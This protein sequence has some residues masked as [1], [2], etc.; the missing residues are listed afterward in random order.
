MCSPRYLLSLAA[1][2]LFATFLFASQPSHFSSRGT[3]CRARTTRSTLEQTQ[4]T[5]QEPVQSNPPDARFPI[6]EQ[7]S[8]QLSLP[9]TF[10]ANL[11]QADPQIAFLA[12]GQRISTFLTRTG[13]DLESARRSI[14]GGQPARVHLEFTRSANAS[15]DATT[16]KAHPI[17]WSGLEKLPAEGNYFIGNN[18]QRWRTHVPHFARAQARA[19][20][21]GVELIAYGR[22]AQL[23]FDLRVAP[24]ANVKNLRIKITGAKD[25]HLNAE[26]DLSLQLGAT[27]IR[28]RKP[29]LYEEFESGELAIPKFI[30]GHSPSSR[31]PI[32][33]SYV[34]ERDGSVGFRI[35]E[36]HAGATLVIDPLLTVKYSTFLGGTG[37]DTANSIAL[38][39]S[40]KIYVGGTTAS[41]STFGEIVTKQNGPGGGSADFFVAKIDP[42]IAGP[43][44]L[45]YLT[46]IGGSGAEA[47]GMIALDKSGNLALTGTTTSADYPVS[48]GSTLTTGPNDIAV[49]ELGPT[50]AT[51]VYSTLF[52][53]S[54]A[55]STQNPGGIAFDQ[56]GEIFIASDTT[57][58]DLP[59]TAGAFQTASGGGTSDGFLGVIRP[60]VTGAT[61]HLKYCTYLGLAAQVGI[62]GVAVDAGGNAYVAGFTSNPGATFP[63]L[64]GYQTTYAGDPFDAFVIKI[65]PSGTGASDLAYGTFLGGAGLDKALAIALGAAMPATA[66][67]T[68]TTQSTNFPTNGSSAAAQAKLKG[69]AN[70]FV[71]AIAQDATTGMTSLLYSS[72]LGG[73]Q[74]DSGLSISVAAPNAVY[75]SGKTTSWDFPW[76]DN[77]QPFNGDG[78]AFVAKL[79]PT[80]SGP[81]SLFYATPLAGTAP[82][83]GKA[84]TDGNAVVA[85]NAGTVYVAGRSTAADFPRSGDPG[86]GLQ[87][88]CAS[89]QELPPAAD[90]FVLAYQEN[91]TP[92]PSVSFTA[93]KIN[94]GAQAVGANNIPPLF[95]NVLNTGD[96]PLIVTSIAITGPNSSSFSLVGTDP[97]IGT[98]LQP[99]ASCAFE[100]GFTP[101][102]VGP[103]EAFVTV[104][105]DAPGSPQVLAV[106]GIGSG[107]FAAL[108]TSSINFGTQ[109]EGSTSRAQQIT[110]VNQ[111]N[112]DLHISN[113]VQAGANPN[114]FGLQGDTCGAVPIPSGSECSVNVVFEPLG[115]G[116][117]QG[118]IDVID[119]SGGLT[120]AKQIVT[121]AGAGVAA[122]PIANLLPQ[123]LTFGVQAVATV[124]GPQSVTLHN[125]G[126]TAL[127]LTQVGFSG[128]DAASFAI[129]AAGTTC[130]LNSGTIA[131]A[132]A[133]TVTVD[134]APQSGGAKTA[135]LSFT[136]NASG[137]P[138][139]VTLTGSATAPTISISPIS[140]NFAPQSV[141]TASALQNITLTNTSASAVSINQIGFTGA[142]ATD[143]SEKDNCPRS[144]GP[145]LNCV[146]GLTFQPLSA[147][148]RA[149]SLVIADDAAGNPHAIALTGVATQSAVSLSPS[150][151]AFASQLVGVSSSVKITVT[152]SGTG[153]LVVSGATIS[154][155]NATDFTANH[156]ACK[157]TVA[158]G[159]ACIISISFS[160][161][162]TG[163]RNA[164]L[165]LTD[166]AADSPQSVPLTGTAMDF[167]IDPP[168]LGTTS[169]T[170]TA[171]QTATYQLDIQSLNGFAGT[172]SFT[173]S[174]ETA[175]PT[176]AACSVSPAM[177]PVAANASTP[178]QVN[179]T[180]TARP[181]SAHTTSP[182]TL[183]ASGPFGPHPPSPRIPA[184]FFV[185]IAAAIF[186]ALVTTRHRQTRARPVKRGLHPRGKRRATNSA[187]SIDT[188][189][190][191][192]QHQHGHGAFR[193]HRHLKIA[194]A[195]TDSQFLFATAALTIALLLTVI[196][197][198]CAKGTT[199]TNTG[200]TGTP[201]GTYTITLSASAP[202]SASPPTPS[203]SLH[204]SLIVR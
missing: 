181:Q 156:D 163:A 48:D 20:V 146:I 116:P 200:A 182:P 157:G 35:D 114:Q 7:H 148:N 76:L 49:T 67:L 101:S 70:A 50:G 23:E 136:D 52:G 106:V 138:Q 137:S 66:Y 93:L 69:T 16:R 169:A 150:S 125:L 47:G 144:L 63:S 152:N 179:V 128:P 120:G 81:A 112:Q 62:G 32:G 4:Q 97:C 167:A 131:I 96:A 18:P 184:P 139:L 143:F 14:P 130:P 151:L 15:A 33:G 65:R 159:A 135:S 5:A 64:N 155:A 113:L 178:F 12:R 154:G 3:T 176:G 174:W 183:T 36:R 89:C 192:C 80:S 203:H 100:V 122:A 43:G 171:G 126:S 124:S 188:Q 186:V 45:K 40:G 87:L 78:D 17:A 83:G 91:A 145:A 102:A 72:Y 134:F 71:A 185:L 10:E 132:S 105:D 173:C 94:F 84:V 68:G 170:V 172:V 142:N 90:A 31:S 34:L 198:A 25:V 168:T 103:Q 160:P 58:T 162:A 194:P 42:T 29:A 199:A 158:P 56:A 21:P 191:G 19:V 54:G 110:I 74:S 55:E 165:V 189:R 196:T 26:G 204:L 59:V 37:E 51:L 161:T 190:D 147:G 53:G 13:I 61:P 28:M 27:R 129:V 73:T 107:P 108:S 109:P 77:F 119:D 197:F 133:C 22:D 123:S 180:T 75:V 95:A 202:T 115:T 1:L 104:A 9:L 60:V 82:P 8:T 117:Y 92:S 30:A 164:V 86:N 149:A 121:L 2:T 195:T 140:M 79:D 41:A 38:D 46:F 85:T 99:R 118:E 201:A 6:R 193:L 44:S 11:G 175:G 39:S 24:G 127:A 187:A 98:Q 88:I 166:N 111:G 141:G 177:L 153:A 57:S